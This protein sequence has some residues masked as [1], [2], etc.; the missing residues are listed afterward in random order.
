MLHS[1]NQC[2]NQ[3]VAGHLVERFKHELPEVQSRMGDGQEGVIDDPVGVEQEIEIQRAWPPPLAIDP[4][5]TTGAFDASE[6]SE[7]GEGG[8]AAG[9]H[10][11]CVE[12]GA[13]P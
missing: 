11:D 9:D 7:Q 3:P 5:A 10:A 4:I 1:L 8:S 2:W 13:L 12:V 6:Q